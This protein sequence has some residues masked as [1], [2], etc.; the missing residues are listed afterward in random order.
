MKTNNYIAFWRMQR[1]L[2][3]EALALKAGLHPNAVAKLER[4][5]QKGYIE[6]WNKLSQ[7][8]GVSME[9]LRN[10]PQEKRT[11]EFNAE[12]VEFPP[13]K[14]IPVLTTIPAGPWYSWVDTL[15]AG[16]ADEYVDR[17]ELKGDH[18]LSVRVVGDSMEPEMREGDLLIIDPE[19]AFKATRHGRIGVVK[20]NG[21][22]KIRLVHLTP[23]ENNYLLEPLNR[24][25]ETEVIPITGTTIYK[26]I[27]KRPTLPGNLY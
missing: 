17:Y 12:L 13:R 6:T 25:Y 26:I 27:D 9:E 5:E 4:G 2:T 1:G 3:Q 14:L 7:V 21:V 11:S 18:I 16:Q 20:F 15:Q 23:D 22:Y 10:G 8:L 24:S 19:Q